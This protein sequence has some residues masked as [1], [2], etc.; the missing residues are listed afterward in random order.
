MM[1]ALVFEPFLFL[2]LNFWWAFF[3]SSIAAGLKCGCFV[4][5]LCLL[6]FNVALIFSRSCATTFGGTS[7]GSF[8]RH[9]LFDL[10]L[11]SLTVVVAG[12]FSVFH[13]VVSFLYSCTFGLVFL[14]A[15]RF[16]FSLAV[17][18]FS[19]TGSTASLFHYR[20]CNIYSGFV[21]PYVFRRL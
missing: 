10:F 16:T 7:N 6:H 4:W 3:F 14:F 11:P 1:A 8:Q 15:G 21:T 20:R 13:V 5:S 9:W 17:F 18:S 2:P 12:L 19:P